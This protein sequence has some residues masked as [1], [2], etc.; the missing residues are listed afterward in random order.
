M[1]AECRIRTS[2]EAGAVLCPRPTSRQV[3]LELRFPT[4]SKSLRGFAWGIVLP[5]FAIGRERAFREA[6]ANF[7]VLQPKAARRKL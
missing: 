7:K 4:D 1:K 5:A 2:V 6:P 3:P